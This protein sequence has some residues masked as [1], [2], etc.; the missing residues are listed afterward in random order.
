MALQINQSIVVLDKNSP[1]YGER[2]VVDQIVDDILVVTYED[3][4]QEKVSAT[5]YALPE[6]LSGLTAGLVI[7][8]LGGQYM[9][10]ERLSNTALL[11][12]PGAFHQPGEWWVLSELEKHGYTVVT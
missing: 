2:A 5:A 6:T 9:V 3:G 10:L 8:R 12:L 7:E 4:S 11:S 1:R